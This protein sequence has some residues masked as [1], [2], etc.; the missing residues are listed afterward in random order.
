L[1]SPY[2][3]ILIGRAQSATSAV[4]GADAHTPTVFIGR[5]RSAKQASLVRQIRTA[6]A[7]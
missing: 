1:G 7:E 2:D 4:P 3:L 6:A 5:L